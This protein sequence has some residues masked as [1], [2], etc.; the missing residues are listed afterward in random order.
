MNLE[1]EKFDLKYYEANFKN[2]KC[3]REFDSYT[4]YYFEEELFYAVNRVPKD[5]DDFVC[6]KRWFYVENLNLM[7]QCHYLREGRMEIGEKQGFD[8]EGNLIQIQDMDEGFPVTWDQ[9]LTVLKSN[10]VPLER[11]ID[12]CR[13]EDEDSSKKWAITLKAVENE[14]E[15]IYVDAV[16]A[17]LVG[18]MCF[19]ARIKQ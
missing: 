17:N 8:T 9:V 3:V 6:L 15:I 4:D 18:R 12:I 2:G 5:G 16:N 10:D 19:K 11:I 1:M 13:Y 14:M 7:L